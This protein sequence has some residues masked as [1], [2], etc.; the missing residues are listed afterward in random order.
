[1]ECKRG[2]NKVFSLKVS[3]PRNPEVVE[4]VGG[5]KGCRG[6]SVRRV[7]WSFVEFS[8]E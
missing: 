1:M 5:W 8:E 3:N 7:L 4:V 2:K 6:C